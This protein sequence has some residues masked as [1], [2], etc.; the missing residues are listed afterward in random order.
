M[1][2]GAIAFLNHARSRERGA[3]SASGLQRG[4]NVI[5]KRKVFIGYPVLLMLV[6]NFPDTLIRKKGSSTQ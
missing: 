3:I 1:N 5:K 4:V 2:I 6:V